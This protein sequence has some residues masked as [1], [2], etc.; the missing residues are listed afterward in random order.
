[1]FSVSPVYNVLDAGVTVIESIAV[2]AS[3]LAASTAAP[4]SS[5]LT[6]RPA[7]TG[8]ALPLFVEIRCTSVASATF[9]TSNVNTAFTF[10]EASTSAVT[11]SDFTVLPLSFV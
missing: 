2:T 5:F 7:I 11:S 8:S 4:S 10:A 9:L 3:F 6:A 1:M